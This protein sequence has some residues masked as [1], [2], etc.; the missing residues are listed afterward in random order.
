[1]QHNVTIM[2]NKTPFTQREREMISTIMQAL[3]Q[4]GTIAC[5]NCGYCRDVCPQKVYIAQSIQAL[6]TFILFSDITRARQSYLWAA[7]GKASTCLQCGAC[8][9]VCPQSIPIVDVL[10]RI[11][12][13]LEDE[14]FELRELA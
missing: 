9:A 2:Q 7:P 11:A 3:Q 6:N 13:E 5:T 12:E 8:E 4:R 10:R 1:M 14:A